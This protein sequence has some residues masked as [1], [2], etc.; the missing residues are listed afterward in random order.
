MKNILFFF[1]VFTAFFF[2]SCSDDDEGSATPI[3]EIETITNFTVTLSP[4][5][6]TETVITLT[7]VNPNSDSPTLSVSGNLA[8]NITYNG[9]ITV[10]NG[11]TDITPEIQTEATDHQVIFGQGGSVSVI[12]PI[13]TDSNGN[14]LGLQFEVTTATA[15]SANLTFTLLHLPTKPNDGS[16]GEAQGVLDVATQTFNVLITN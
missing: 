11:N 16:L 3:N 9:V 1:I 15:G 4:Q 5:E 12:E 2:S 7:S 10:A 13:D 6:S 14:V 8:G